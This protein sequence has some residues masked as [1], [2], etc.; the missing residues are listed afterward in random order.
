MNIILL[1]IDTLRYDYVGFHGK[2]GWI[3]TP[4][5]NR[6]AAKSWVFDRCLINGFPTMSHRRDVITGQYGDP[7]NLWMP[8]QVNGVPTIPRALAEKGYCTQLIH[9]TPHMVNGGMSFDWPFHAWTFIRGAEVDRPWIGGPVPQLPD[10]WARD[11]LF[12]TMDAG[13]FEGKAFRF[14]PYVRAN[15]NRRDDRD[16]HSAKLFGAGIEFLRDNAGRGDSHRAPFFL[17]LDSFDPHEPWD[18]PPEYARMYDADPNYDGRIDPRGFLFGDASEIS[19]AAQRRVAAWYAGKVTWVDRWVG[20]LLDALEESGL[21][22]NTAIVVTAD[23]GTNLGERGIFRK[24]IVVREQEAHVPLMIHVPG[25]GQ[26]RTSLLVQPQDIFRTIMNIA[27]AETPASVQESY[28]VLSLAKEGK[29]SPRRIAIAGHGVHSWPHSKRSSLFT[30][31]DEDEYL[32]VSHRP[33]QEELYLYGSLVNEAKQR[34]EVVESLREKGLMELVRRGGNPALI[35]W[36]K[37]Q[38]TTPFPKTRTVEPAGWT[39]YWGRNYL[40]W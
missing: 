24:D 31:F 35:D 23:H 28:D 14:I 12:D 7:F 18:V 4:N 2:N 39:S 33:E 6:L 15:R 5:L 10:N 8:L 16:W 37:S 26:G 20:E 22:K 1:V 11:P 30:V 40:Q 34:P 9:D 36:V 17:W 32:L 13:L 3:Q 19:E 27:G 25:Q 38:G 21:E 29:D